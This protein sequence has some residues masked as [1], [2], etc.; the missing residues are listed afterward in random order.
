LPRLVFLHKPQLMHSAAGKAGGRAGSDD[1]VSAETTEATHAQRW[2]LLLL[3]AA[4]RGGGNAAAEAAVAAAA[5]I[6]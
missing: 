5:T 2:L 4:G 3:L 1:A 6:R